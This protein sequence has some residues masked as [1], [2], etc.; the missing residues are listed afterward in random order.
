MSVVWHESLSNSVRACNKGLQDFEGNGDDLW[1]SGVEGGL[2]W[3][4]QLWNDWKYFSTSL[5]KHVEYS[6]NG[7]ESIW[8]HLFSDSFEEDWQVVMIIQL[9]DINFPINF[10]LWGLVLNGN[11]QVSSVV[12]QSEFTH[13]DWS[14]IHSTSNWFLY[15]R[16]R[17][18]LV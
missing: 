13:W 9:L 4:N 16:L 12:E 11:R 18:G 5:F 14:S 1:V 3:D 7:K 10:V 8:V 6:L 2:D 17:L 15:D